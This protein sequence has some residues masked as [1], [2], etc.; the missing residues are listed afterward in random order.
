MLD[1][2][3][4]KMTNNVKDDNGVNTWDHSLNESLNTCTGMIGSL[5]NFYDSGLPFPKRLSV[6]AAHLVN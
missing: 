5:S 4:P 3:L 1:S 6:L 2:M